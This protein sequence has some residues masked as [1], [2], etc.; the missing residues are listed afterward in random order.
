MTEH[1]ALSP[2]HWKVEAC[3]FGR[4]RQIGFPETEAEAV[5]YFEWAIT[6]YPTDYL[7]RLREGEEVRKVQPAD[8]G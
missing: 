3:V 2:T 4:W 6:D 1:K 5:K 7:I 8:G